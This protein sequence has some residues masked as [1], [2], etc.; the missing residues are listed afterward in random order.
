MAERAKEHIKESKLEVSSCVLSLEL[1]YAWISL[2]M[3]STAVSS[4][5]TDGRACKTAHQ[6]I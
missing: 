5:E 3:N 2:D 1:L 6:K 4:D